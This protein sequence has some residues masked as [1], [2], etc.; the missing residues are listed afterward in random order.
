MTLV[1]AKTL[2]TELGV[3]VSYVYTH[4]ADLGALRLPASNKRGTS[5]PRLRFDLEEVRRRLSC[6]ADRKS[7]PLDPAP[8]AGLRH[9][10]RGRVGTNVELVPIKGRA[11]R[12]RVG[13]G[14][15]NAYGESNA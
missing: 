15:A 11:R 7:E 8:Q 14:V 9:G 4:A 1:D 5:K 13:A 12:Q 10:R 6:Y 3:N 2:A